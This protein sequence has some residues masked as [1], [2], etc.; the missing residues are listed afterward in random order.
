MQ[1]SSEAG[2]AEASGGTDATPR[3]VYIDN[4][5]IVLSSL[6]VLFHLSV[7]YGAV[8]S[9]AYVETKA[10]FPA[11]YFLTLFTA[12]CQ[13]FFMGMFFLISGYF[14]YGTLERKGTGRFLEERLVRLGI[15]LVLYIF[16][17]E[18]LTWYFAQSW[19]PAHLSF[20]DILR[21]GYGR[22]VG[23]MWFLVALGCFSVLYAAARQAFDGLRAG[24]D[25]R[26][27]ALKD[28]HIATF[29]LCLSFVTFLV[30]LEFPVGRTLPVVGFNVAHFSQ[31]IALFALG[32]LA[33]RHGLREPISFRQA[34]RWL[35]FAGAM[36][37]FG[38]PALFLAGGA[39]SG[40]VA[41][42]LGGPHWQSFAYA[43]WE[44]A[45][46]IAIIAALLGIM[47]VKWNTAGRIDRELAGAA[48]ALYVF[49]P[50]IVVAVSIL[51]RDWAL[52]PLAKFIVLSPIALAAS[53]AVALSVRKIPYARRVF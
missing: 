27:F 20:L 29:I 51:F 31:Y 38:F 6:V 24:I 44:Q 33:A 19:K 32:I 1:S 48:Y 9:W 36:V 39:V 52:P 8:G 45:T 50:P 49:H 15:P 3:L 5:R 53:F 11:S 14:T 2:G 43:F 23:A 16:F 41:P 25:E 17:L 26:P 22:G 34:K 46:G 21:N 4:I 7:T 13:S 10:E 42:F 35:L 18:P 40:E 12:T 28:A 30:R 47:R 37:L